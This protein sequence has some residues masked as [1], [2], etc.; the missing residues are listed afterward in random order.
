MGGWTRR[1]AVALGVTLLAIVC[2]GGKVV[3]GMSY[4]APAPAVMTSAHAEVPRHV[5]L[6]RREPAPT[7]SRNEQRRAFAAL[8]VLMAQGT[9]RNG[10]P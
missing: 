10:A 9:G 1:G 8:L 2:T 7:V 6:Q 5:A 4:T 3:R